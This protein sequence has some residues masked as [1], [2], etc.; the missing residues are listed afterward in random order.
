MPTVRAVKLPLKHEK[1]KFISNQITR[2]VSEAW[3]IYQRNTALCTEFEVPNDLQPCE[4][5]K[6]TDRHATLQEFID[7]FP[8]HSFR[9]IV[10]P[11][12]AQARKLMCN[13]AG[14]GKGFDIKAKSSKNKEEKIPISGYVPVCQQC[15]DDAELEE[16]MDNEGTEDLKYN[17]KTGDFSILQTSSI[18]E[19]NTT[20]NSW[21]A[22]EIRVGLIQKS[23]DKTVEF[24]KTFN[25]ECGGKCYQTF[26]ASSKVFQNK[27]VKS[28]KPGGDVP[29]KGVE[30]TCVKIKT[31][32]YNMEDAVYFPFLAYAIGKD[33][34]PVV[35]DYDM[36]M[37][38]ECD[39]TQKFEVYNGDPNYYDEVAI[40]VAKMSACVLQEVS[41][42]DCL[43]R[44]IDSFD[45]IR[46]VKS[47]IK[48]KT[49]KSKIKDESSVFDDIIRL[50]GERNTKNIGLHPN[51]IAE[52]FLNPIIDK[53]NSAE[54]KAHGAIRHGSENENLIAPQ[55]FELT[56]EYPMWTKEEDVR[57]VTGSKL[58]QQ[59]AETL[60]SGCC[61]MVN[62]WWLMPRFYISNLNKLDKIE[63]EIEK[64]TQDKMQEGM[65]PALKWATA[66]A[67][68]Y[69]SGKLKNCPFYDPKSAMVQSYKQIIDEIAK[70][71]LE[72]SKGKKNV[73]QGLKPKAAIAII[74]SNI[75]KY[76]SGT[77]PK[78]YQWDND[79]LNDIDPRN[80]KWEAIN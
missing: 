24:C 76:E 8:T 33:V 25:V 68:G 15:I 11:V 23:Q 9:V 38:A 70:Y 19:D 34:N 36:L 46:E 53:C 42:D 52:T 22:T 79:F 16:N 39:A 41:V 26:R 29:P 49:T 20:S 2:T 4:N 12:S 3:K 5:N 28:L 37:V 40:I 69:T 7:G 67:Q 64:T 18:L 44:K 59:F 56:E 43:A 21:P 62:P 72:I 55:A 14:V 73:L 77:P 65:L 13:N 6:K 1:E 51:S 54:H 27:A 78:E 61:T 31:E 50:S 32:L 63:K 30:R 58:P 10:R 80:V 35:S 66:W 75:V 45:D 60:M 57:E 74:R 47:R 17:I 71:I 48:D